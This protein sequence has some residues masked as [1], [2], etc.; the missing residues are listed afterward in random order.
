MFVSGDGLYVVDHDGGTPERIGAMPGSGWSVTWSPDGSQIAYLTGNRRVEVWVAN[1][2]GTDAHQILADEPTELRDTTGLAWS[3]AGDRLA[4][5]AGTHEPSGGSIYTFAP[6]GSDFT[7]VIVGGSAPVWSPDGSQIAYSI[8]CDFDQ[9]FTTCI[10]FDS[11]T[12]R[13]P[14]GLAIADADGSDA[15]AF[16]FAASGPWHPGASATDEPVPSPVETPTPMRSDSF[17]RVDGEV[18]DRI[19]QGEAVNGWPTTS[20]NHAGVY[21]WDGSACGPPQPQS[22][23]PPDSGPRS[24][25]RNE[26]PPPSFCSVSSAGGFMHNGYGSGD[27][28]LL[29]SVLPEGSVPGEGVVVSVAGRTGVYR[30][31]DARR[32]RW[33]VDIA[34]TTISIRMNAEPGTSRADLEDGH[35]IIGSMR[36]QAQ[37][38]YLG[39][40]LV[41]ILTN[42]KWDS[43]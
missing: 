22:A 18:F 29:L 8:Q 37:D 23:P 24:Y 38:S 40:R 7:P 26:D 39:F 19:A 14:P 13:N 10:Q 28:A 2:D 43:G 9:T 33:I 32:E 34:G 15:Q 25:S 6:D 42:G 31:I 36:A 4:L 5:G 35:A 30:R 17:A 11:Q 16:G 12:G 3:P 27:V 20:K 1:A 21:S 41:F